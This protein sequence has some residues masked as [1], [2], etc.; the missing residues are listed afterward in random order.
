MADGGL[1]TAKVQCTQGLYKAMSSPASIAVALALTGCGPR[2]ID[3]ALGLDAGAGEG[4]GGGGESDSAGG[5]TSGATTGE[6]GGE[7]DQWED[8]QLDASP[9][10]YP[11]GEA[12]ISLACELGE[13]QEERCGNDVDDDCD[14]RVDENELL[15]QECFSDCQRPGIWACNRSLE[16]LVCFDSDC[17]VQP[18]TCGNGL[19][20]KDES[21]DVSAGDVPYENVGMLDAYC[22]VDC[23]VATRFGGPCWE[24]SSSGPE[25]IFDCGAKG[26]VCSELI[27]TCVPK[28]GEGGWY[29]CPRLTRPE[30]DE[31]YIV[32]VGEG[33][34]ARAPSFPMVE[35]EEGECH[36][37]CSR[38]ADC[39][40]MLN[41]C[42]M[43]V[44]VI[45]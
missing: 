18:G 19:R 8:V 45:W 16:Q 44:C 24:W 11:S 27:R 7:V 34:A 20:D 42:Y 35:S 23:R 3:L 29:R 25:E 37:S 38:D 15:G 14:G 39:P 21:C 6:L 40:E 17:Y 28:V 31:E 22:R 12:H 1:Y 32:R 13:V 30:T 43:G 26:L 41:T 36:I 9:S 10:G 4:V 2:P 5:N 33:E